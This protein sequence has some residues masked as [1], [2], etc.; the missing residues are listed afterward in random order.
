MRSF[1]VVEDEIVLQPVL[2]LMHRVILVETDVLIFDAA[3][4]AFAKDIIED[5]TASVHADLDVGGLQAGG[6]G[7]I[8]ELCALVGVE[9]SGSALA[10]PIAQS[11]E[12]V[13][14]YLEFSDSFRPRR[15]RAGRPNVSI[16]LIKVQE[17]CMADQ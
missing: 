14:R 13:V 8:C 12:T 3:P 6:E 16:S 1:I 9:D 17:L 5:A 2:Q 7:I 4:K 11:S 15:T 10:E